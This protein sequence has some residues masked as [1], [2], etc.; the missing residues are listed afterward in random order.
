[1]DPNNQQ[2]Q[3]P[4]PPTDPGQAFPPPQLPQQPAAN[5]A[6]VPTP[7]VIAPVDT[8]GG[9]PML[10][11]VPQQPSVP[12]AP[13]P[14]PEYGNPTPPQNQSPQPVFP[15]SI[16]QGLNQGLPP[17]PT[18]DSPAPLPPVPDAAG[19]NPLAVPSMANSE[20]QHS[21]GGSKKVLGIVIVVVGV[22]LL[23]GIVLLGIRTFL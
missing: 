18:Q 2:A 10:A 23:I 16:D 1:M 19:N 20:S 8:L 22:L 21:G 3:P 7:S 6:P 11:A 17:S 5:P 15:S 14:M 12:P 13:Q 4:M 9:D